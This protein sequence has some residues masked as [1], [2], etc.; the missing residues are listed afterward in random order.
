[1]ESA[2]TLA[3]AGLS[4]AD[5]PIASTSYTALDTQQAAP[6][7]Y[8]ASPSGFSEAEGPTPVKEDPLDDTPMSHS[9]ASDGQDAAAPDVNGLNGQGV[10]AHMAATSEGGDDDAYDAKMEDDSD[11]SDGVVA[12]GYAGRSATNAAAS[13][14]GGRKGK[15]K[16]DLP[17][18]LDADLYGLRRSVCPLTPLPRRFDDGTG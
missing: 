4:P 9:D 7:Q 15:G 8:D 10:D 6:L 18:D 2:S 12:P 3:V 16:L 1:M 11:E 5:P 17:E 14:R 13:A